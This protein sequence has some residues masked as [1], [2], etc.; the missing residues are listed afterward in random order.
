ML[1]DL[2]LINKK[3]AVDYLDRQSHARL[4]PDALPGGS[5]STFALATLVIVRL[6][7][8]RRS[9]V[10]GEATSLLDV[11]ITPLFGHSN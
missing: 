1:C 3:R 6:L 7:P 9:S 10:V 5:T 11:S 4:G 8:R 2:R